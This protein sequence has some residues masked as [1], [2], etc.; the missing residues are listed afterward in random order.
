MTVHL[1]TVLYDFL[2]A[3]CNVIHILL[4]RM[5]SN[6]MNCNNNYDNNI[7][8]NIDNENGCNENNDYDSSN[9]D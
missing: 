9:D 2:C 6:Q 1:V 5:K 7:D 4:D 3:K 8:D